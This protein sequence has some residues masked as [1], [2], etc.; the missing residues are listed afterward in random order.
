MVAMAVPL[1]FLYFLGILL[2]KYLPRSQMLDGR[3]S[4]PR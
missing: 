2:C 4:D 1:L 3:A